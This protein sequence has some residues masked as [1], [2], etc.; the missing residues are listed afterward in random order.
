MPSPYQARPIQ[1]AA[2]AAAWFLILTL[3]NITAGGSLRATTLYA[4]PVVFAARHGIRLGFVFAAVGALSAWAGGSIP[5]P[6]LDEPLW[7]EGLWAFLKLSAIAVGTRIA[8]HQVR[9]RR[10]T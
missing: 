3:L 5:H 9:S 2:I 8:L 7:I 10:S 6:G 4:V 1:V